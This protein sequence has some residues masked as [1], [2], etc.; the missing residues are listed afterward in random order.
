MQKVKTILI[1]LLHSP[2]IFA[3]L[4]AGAGFL[5]CLALIYV[6]Q[7]FSIRSPLEKRIPEETG[8]IIETVIVTPTPEPPVL[9]S[10][11]PFIRQGGEIIPNATS[12]ADKQ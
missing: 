6:L 12:S 5:F 8:V 2:I 7:N 11:V 3:A 9:P 4:S 10:P 1:N